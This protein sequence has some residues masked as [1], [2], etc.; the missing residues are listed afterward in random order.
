MTQIDTD[1]SRNG[2]ELI[3]RDGTLRDPADVLRA[4]F[5][6]SVLIRVIRA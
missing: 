4:P 2:E 5:F 1:E 6:S 3:V